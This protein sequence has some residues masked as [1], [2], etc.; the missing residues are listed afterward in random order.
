MR[1]QAQLKNG[2]GTNQFQKF[3]TGS[4]S[5]SSDLLKIIKISKKK[6][7][8]C[9][10]HISHALNGVY[11]TNNRKKDFLIFVIDGIG[12]G[13]TMSIFKKINNDIITEKKCIYPHSIGLFYSTFTQFLGFNVNEGESKVMGLASYGE[14]IFK[15]FIIDEIK[16]IKQDQIFND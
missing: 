4:L 12:D 13:E 3:W 5:F 6:I 9:P 15:D 16:G 14:P 10:H 8:Y 1:Y 11:F 7:Y 2:N